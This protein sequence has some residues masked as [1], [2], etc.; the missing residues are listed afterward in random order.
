[1]LA[2]SE[3]QSNGEDLPECNNYMLV[4]DY[5][6]TESVNNICEAVIML[7]V[8]YFVFNKVWPDEVNC[9]LE[10]AQMRWFNIYGNDSNTKSKSQ[11][12][13]KKVYAFFR[14]L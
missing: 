1:M 11:V 9:F 12:I 14:K 13:T 3:E 2:S 8:S 4:V 10:Y 5:V 7:V 6:Q